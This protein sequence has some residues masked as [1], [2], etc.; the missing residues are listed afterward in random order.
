M[1]WNLQL[2]A[3]VEDGDRRSFTLTRAGAAVTHSASICQGDVV[4]IDG[5]GATVNRVTHFLAIPGSQRAPVSIAFAVTH[6]RLTI[7]DAEKLLAFGF[8]YGGVD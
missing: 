7:E 3:N 4:D 5:I 2:D 8:T 1:S 6:E